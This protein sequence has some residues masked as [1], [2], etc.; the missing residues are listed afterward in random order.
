MAPDPRTVAAN[1]L[2]LVVGKGK[3]LD[4]IL[5]KAL[6]PLGEARE[7]AFAQ[8][9][10]YG[11][12]R[13]YWRL[14]PQLHSLLRKPLRARDRDVEML[15]LI[16]LYQ[17]Q[18]LSTPP[19][20]AVGA[21]V[22]ACRGFDKPWAK[23]L[24]NGTLRNAIRGRDKLETAANSS[25]SA[26]TA[27]PEWFVDALR[28][29][30]PG[31]WEALLSANNDH[32]PCTLR[33][34]QRLVSRERYL[35]LLK[36]AGIET[37]ATRHAEQG[38]RL[39]RPVPVELLP[40]FARGLVSVQDEA[41]QLAAAL[42]QV[43]DSARVLDA[44][45]APG[46]KTA[47]ILETGSDSVEVVAIDRSAERVALLEATLARLGLRAL[48]HTAD[49]AATDQWWDGVLFDRVLLDA[50]CSGSGVVRRHPDIK[51]HRR[52]EDI[53]KFAAQQ[54][55]LLNSLW[56]LLK[57]GGKLVYGSCSVLKAENDQVIAELLDSRGDA[58]LDRIAGEWG[59]ATR[60]G[61]QILTGRDQMD[62]FYY[63]RL[64]KV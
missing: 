17:L 16:G 54:A 48:V 32:P 13:W 51:I 2:T 23:G 44:C 62:G 34:N 10:V 38:I 59:M 9:L 36:E 55:A 60:C 41:A 3:S 39:R 4:G 19:H 52:A 35:E 28:R 22:E 45:A 12:L 61:R 5:G 47:H 40:E 24:I 1:A 58:A 49:A 7:R 18:Y 64:T 30:W 15:L 31:H 6:A 26:R 63:A 14:L 56:P 57:P 29:D 37:V 8:E 21:T 53:P 20:A 46:G 27:H 42:L 33:V 43:P 50:P 25:R 11:V